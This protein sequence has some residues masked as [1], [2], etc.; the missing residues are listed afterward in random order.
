MSVML[1]TTNYP[2]VGGG[3]SRYLDGLVGVAN[4]RVQVA[5]FGG[6]QLPPAGDGLVARVS[7]I[8]WAKRTVGRTHPDVGILAGQPHLALGAI[9]ARRPFAVVLHGGEWEDYP[10]GGRLLA[11]VLKKSSVIVVSS[12]ATGLQW[13]PASLRG[14][15]MVIRPGIPEFTSRQEAHPSAEESGTQGA[16]ELR[17]LAVARLSPRKGFVR[18]VRA[19]QQCATRGV[20]MT[21]DIVGEGVMMAELQATVAGHPNINLRGHVPDDLLAELYRRAD[22]FA[23]VPER[24]SGG[25][26]WEGF[27]IVY[28]E[29]AAL[30]LPVVGTRTGGVSEA[31]CPEGSILLDETCGVDEVATALE[32]LALNPGRRRLM[33]EANRDW[34]TKQTWA[35]RKPLVDDLL[36]R[37][38]TS[39]KTKGQP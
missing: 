1:L 6:G 16:S 23:L 5:G 8:C 14:R 18:L 12:E 13:V 33:G 22:V 3:V 2:P 25:E 10:N 35:H 38:A 21:L 15:V 17:V 30:G 11:R 9:L 36:A 4:G 27:G 24:I 20:G 26:G 37:M 34:A 39:P 29:A 19:V 31:T 7:Q 32:S 28:L